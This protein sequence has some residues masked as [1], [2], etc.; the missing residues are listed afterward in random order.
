MIDPATNRLTGTVN[1]VPLYGFDL[2]GNQT[3]VSPWAMTFDAESRMTGFTSTNSGSGTYTYDGE[4]RRVLKTVGATTTLYVYDAQGNR[5]AEYASTVA[6]P[7][8]ATCYETVDT[9]GSVRAVTDGFGNSIALH[10]YL[11]F[12]EELATANRVGVPGYG[13]SD[14]LVDRFTGKERDA[15][16][17]LDWWSSR[18]MSSQQGRFTS[19]DPTG[20]SSGSSS[21]P[22]S[23]NEYSYARNNPQLFTDPDGFNYQVCDANGNCSKETI[24]DQEFESEQSNG[25]AN[26]EYFN[27]ADGTMYHFDTNGD[28]VSDGTF[29]QVDVD[30]NSS[31][32][33]LI[34]R[35][36]QM[37]GAQQKFIGLFAGASV[38][39]GATGGSITY[40]TGATSIGAGAG[41]ALS[42]PAG[43]Q[44]GAVVGGYIL[45][46]H[47]AEQA[48]ERGVTL[49][50]IKAAV[51][52]VAKSNPQNGWDSV[53]R[54]YTDTC[55]V[56]VNTVTGT[57]VTVINKISR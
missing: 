12:G 52:G 35:L 15:E 50:E 45:T 27:Q 7:P 37:A 57:I 17:G 4:G 47:A 38:A 14:G 24:S 34:Q 48:A 41:T 29:R 49:Q 33:A 53:K 32:G 1:G 30:V 16:T 9:L 39:V 13:I 51:E 10:D 42:I 20:S 54:F 31:G 2:A 6:A 28:R 26:G 3:T 8:C 5:A 43:M 36:G 55:E 44:P 11:P 18:Y 46:E 40:L 21:D 23:W 56:R 25:K 22:Q 19:P